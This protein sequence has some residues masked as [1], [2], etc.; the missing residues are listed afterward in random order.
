MSLSA[1]YYPWQQPGKM[2]IAIWLGFLTIQVAMPLSH[3]LSWVPAYPLWLGWGVPHHR[4]P[5]RP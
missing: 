3:P 4:L 5:S 1:T 2:V